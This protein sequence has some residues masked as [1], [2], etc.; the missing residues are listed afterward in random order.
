[1]GWGPWHVPGRG[2]RP[3][4][5]HTPPGRAVPVPLRG[6]AWGSRAPGRRRRRAR[7]ARKPRW[8]ALG[9]YPRAALPSPGWA[10]TPHLPRALPRGGGHP[11]FRAPR[12]LCSSPGT[13]PGQRRLDP[14]RPERKQSG[15]TP[16]GRDPPPATQI[17]FQR[18]VYAE[19]RAVHLAGLAL[20]GEESAARG[21]LVPPSPR[22]PGRLFRPPRASVYPSVK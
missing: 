3:V 20:G 1:M 12:V 22:G 18:G 13:D 17:S 4:D 21:P 14:G 19:P 10:S 16:M 6:P 7:C 15:A 5:A 11:T 9:L 8:V 2:A